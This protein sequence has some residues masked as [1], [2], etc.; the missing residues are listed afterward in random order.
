[1]QQG[2]FAA[3]LP[4]RAAP[5]P[6]P[7][8]THALS[9]RA[10]ASAR[11]A[12]WPHAGSRGQL[13]QPADR[14]SWPCGRQGNKSCTVEAMGSKKQAQK[15]FPARDVT[16]SQAE[17]D[18]LK[19]SIEQKQQMPATH[20]SGKGRFKPPAAGEVDGP[21]PGATSDEVDAIHTPAY[22]DTQGDD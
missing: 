4:V 1:M 6:C 17:A 21:T 3:P 7:A 22:L 2:G 9:Q 15:R 10:Q 20:R 19:K 18:Q 8:T 5:L 12:P 11:S 14:P 13:Q 16:N